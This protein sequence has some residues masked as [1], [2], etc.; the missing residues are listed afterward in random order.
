VTSRLA[1][2]VALVTGAA[3]GIGRAVAQRFV[4]EDAAVTCLDLA[5]DRLAQLETDLGERAL[6]R[7]CDVTVADDLE[8]AVAATVER[9]GPIDVVVANAGRGTYSP[10]VDHD[11][12]EWR[13]L[14]DL[15]LT[16]VFLTIRATAPA[17]R[18]GGS[19]ITI[20]SLNAVQ[21]AAG[22]SAYCA[23]KAGAV[24]LTRV[25]AM[26]LGH[27]GIRAN[28]IAPGLVETDA[29]AAF[30]QLPG[31]VDDFVE[32]TTVGRFARPG[33]VADLA[34]FLA[35]DESTF[36]SG[37]VQLVDGGASTK[38]YPDLPGAFARLVDGAS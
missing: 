21:P 17:M 14:I 23:A 6:T 37:S 25:A 16:G 2:K 7:R 32:N 4:A 30:W 20:A 33:D 3:S 15:C 34:L 19:I 36:V 12:D 13:A 27:R 29:T 18:D 24:A 31:L 35:G 10:I 9:F 8:A 11:V 5:D 1:G 28:A 26:E 22:M 38:R